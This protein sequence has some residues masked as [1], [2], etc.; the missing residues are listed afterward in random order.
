MRRLKS[1]MYV[2]AAV[3]ALILSAVLAGCEV[4]PDPT[5]DPE[6]AEDVYY[7]VT[8]HLDGG[9]LAGQD[10]SAGLKVKENTSVSLADY[11]PEKSGYTF[12]GWAVD[13][14]A[15]TGDSVTVT[16]DIVLTAIWEVLP[17]AEYTVTFD[18]NGGEMST[19]TVTVKA[20][21]SVRLADYTPVRAGFRFVGWVDANGAAVT[22]ET[23]T[24]NA[25]LAF[26]AN[27]KAEETDAAK[28]VFELSEDGT[29]YIL[30]DLADDFDVENVVV[31]GTFNGKPVKEIGYNAFSYNDVLK[32]I[33]LTNCTSLELIGSWNFTN[34]PNLVAVDLGGL[35][36]LREIETACFYSATALKTINLKGLTGLERIGSSCFHGYSDA[37]ACPVEVLNF[38]D[39]TALTDIGQQSFWYLTELKVLDFSNTKIESFERQTIKECPK[40]ESVSLPATLKLD[41]NTSEFITGSSSLKEI[42]VHPLNLFL[43]CE[44]GALYDIEKT[45]LFKYP[46]KSDAKV[47]TAPAALRII[48]AQAFYEATNLETVDLSG[49]KI[50]VI[51]WAAFDGCSSATVKVGFGKNG[52]YSDGVAVSCGTSWADG[53]ASVQYATV[54]AFAI[55][56]IKDNASTVNSALEARISATYGDAACTVSVKVNGVAVVGTDGVYTLPLTLGENTIEI[57]AASGENTATRTL[58]V[59]LVSGPPTVTTTVVD[60]KTYTGSTIDFVITAK[61]ADGTPIGQSGISVFTDWGYG[62]NPLTTMAYTM[63]D[64]ADGTVSVSIDFNLLWDWMF[65]EGGAFKLVITAKDGDQSASV[66]Y[67]IE[68]I[69]ETEG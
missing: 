19:V 51:G 45:I 9:E 46:A 1:R 17:A 60:G 31:P 52:A 38:R 26:A 4:I 27:W 41:E 67:T 48:S 18:P 30:S 5:P 11:V 58:H 56:G 34:C 21:E 59:E 53:V 15:V 32:T 13:G 6:P 8:F 23:V 40:L 16:K 39:C 54:F 65:Y 20:G 24:V 44:N 61:K 62:L 50:T 55:E 64:N 12:I 63:T 49:A 2:L 57:T 28:F 14:T 25:D 22:E 36:E 33:D 37:T 29:F 7:H 66:T 69:Q 42:N 35:S 47:Y 10:V 43:V 68:H 3:L